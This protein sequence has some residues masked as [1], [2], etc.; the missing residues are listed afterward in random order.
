MLGLLLLMACGSADDLRKAWTGKQ[1]TVADLIDVQDADTS[2]DGTTSD[3][4]GSL[5]DGT[6]SVDAGTDPGFDSPDTDPGFALD[7]GLEICVPDCAGKECGSNG[8]GAACGACTAGKECLEGQ[9][10][11]LTTE[12]F[13]E[14]PA[15]SFW[16]GSPSADDEAN[17]CPDEYSGACLEELGRD[18]GEYL[19]YVKL[20]HDFEMQIYEV[21]QGEFETMIGWNPS[22][23]GPNG[24]G[25][26]CGVNCPV[27]TVSWYDAVA[28]ANQKSIGAGKTTCYVF[29]NVQCED[30]TAQGS[31][32]MAC[33]NT[34]QGGID[35]ATVTLNG[36]G[37]PYDCTGYRL[38]TESE[39]EYA[40]RA[41]SNTAFY[42]SDGND[43]T[44][45]YEG[46]DNLDLNLDQIGWYGGNSTASYSN[47]DCS[48]W[49]SG[50]KNCGTQ[51]RGGKE[52]NEWNLYDMTG[53]VW[54]W[55]LDWKE[56]YPGGTYSAP[57]EDPV[58]TGGSLRVRRGGSWLSNSHQCRS[59]RRYHDLPGFRDFFLGFRLSRTLGETTCTPSC[60]GKQCGDDSCGGSCGTCT[61]YANSFCNASN[62]CNC[63]EDTCLGLSKECGGPYDDGC[64]STVTCPGCG[65][66]EDCQSGTCVFTACTGK[67]C[68]DD[69]CGG[70]CG[71]CT[72]YPNSYCNASNQC[73]CTEDTCLGLSKECGG[74]YSN[75]CGGTVTCPACSVCGEECQ[76]GS[77]EFTA[78]DGKECGRVRIFNPVF[79][80]LVEYP[81]SWSGGQ[82]TFFRHPGR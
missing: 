39:W 47:H 1:T 9:C 51:P 24:S 59:A 56:I 37:K 49:F 80:H 32:Y 64:G 7:D 36:V 55:V 75:G 53:N 11:F 12:G 74:P 25:G 54:E 8:C 22:H 46:K 82:T 72:Q 34:T 19:H 42:P 81:R 70:S 27:E 28:Y 57:D 45:T 62:Q 31:N 2:D 76:A 5:P 30:G 26:D 78:C 79:P 10:E 68:G 41:G 33:M 71:Q 65:C 23:F 18:Y 44:I 50:A 35:S 6:D 67:E 69:G 29:A 21:T 48:S 13:V 38:P 61:Q 17:G 40:A 73:D 60:S 63:T 14:I 52:P 16:M 77:C 15:G 58:G 20:T 4:P 3:D 43:G 66:G